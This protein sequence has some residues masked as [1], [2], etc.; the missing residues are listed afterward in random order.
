MLSVVLVDDEQMALELCEQAIRDALPD[1]DLACFVSPEK[2]I[3]YAKAI[4][5][6]IAFLDIEMP[7]MNGIEL[8]KRLKEIHGTTNIIFVTGHTQYALDSYTVQASEYLLKPVD[9]EKVHDALEHLRYPIEAKSDMRVR[10]QTFGN[11]EVFVDGEPLDF[12]LAKS[13]ELLAYLIDRNGAVCNNNEIMAVIWEDKT[14]SPSLKSNFRNLVS[15]LTQTLASKGAADL[16]VKQ[17]GHLGINPGKVSCDVYDFIASVPSAVN[18]YMGEYM[19]QYSWAEF[20]NAHLGYD[21]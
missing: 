13:K 7:G 9:Q 14:D 11:F 18:S 3:Q 2:A 8:A 16:L 6:D 19:K 12:G 4:K 10:V 21:R 5:V 17:R 20:T 1:C 15:D